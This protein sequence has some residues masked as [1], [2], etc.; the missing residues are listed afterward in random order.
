[1]GIIMFAE[2]DLTAETPLAENAPLLLMAIQ[3]WRSATTTR[4]AS[5]TAPMLRPKR[6]AA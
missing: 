4:M 3:K 6:S 1:M 2:A 5:S